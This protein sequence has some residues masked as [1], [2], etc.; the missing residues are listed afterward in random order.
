MCQRT[1]L[2]THHF[3]LAKLLKFQETFPEKFL[4]SG[5]GA[6]APTDNEHKKRG[7]HRVFLYCRKMLELRSKPPSLTFLIRK[8]SQRISHRTHHFI[9]AKFLGFQ[10][11]FFK[12]S[13]VSGFGA[14]AP[15]LNADI[16]KHGDAVLFYSPNNDK[17]CSLKMT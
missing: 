15:T 7:L 9:L 11:T 12:K 3:I 16:K 14:E 13:F 8:V 17:N 5:L 6:E 4:V 2:K 10:R 1:L